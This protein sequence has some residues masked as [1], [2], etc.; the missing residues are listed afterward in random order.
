LDLGEAGVE[1]D[2]A[3]DL[4]STNDIIGGNSGGPL[5]KVFIEHNLQTADNMDAMFNCLQWN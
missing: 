5:C 1:F 4:S 2:D 3:H